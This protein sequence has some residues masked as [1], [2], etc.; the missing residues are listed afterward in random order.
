M[1]GIEYYW[2][3]SA[4]NF[5][6]KISISGMCDSSHADIVEDRKTTLGMITYLNGMPIHWR[7]YKSTSVYVATTG[8]EYAAASEAAS[9][10]IWT[11]HLMEAMSMQTEAK[12]SL[13]MDNQP[14][15]D[16]IKSGKLTDAIKALDVRFHHIK[17]MYTRGDLSLDYIKSED[18][19]ADLFTKPLGKV[20]FQ[21]LVSKIMFFKPP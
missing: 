4:N 16:I 3:G 19:V 1:S 10:L 20:K 13:Y 12:V 6:Q 21:E 15:I 11:K 7:S 17:D 2:P 8:A 14:A 5:D 9:E 18:N